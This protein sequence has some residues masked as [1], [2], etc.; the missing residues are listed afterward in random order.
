MAMGKECQG[1]GWLCPWRP[2]A[3]KG[4]SGIH[5]LIAMK[6]ELVDVKNAFRNVANQSKDVLDAAKGKKRR[7]RKPHYKKKYKKTNNNLKKN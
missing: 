7:G 5:G 3:K 2:V 6:K 1:L 4:L